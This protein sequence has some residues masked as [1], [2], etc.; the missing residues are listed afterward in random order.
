MLI[1]KKKVEGPIFQ[2]N[3]ELKEIPVRKTCLVQGKSHAQFSL[4]LSKFYSHKQDNEAV[5]CM[6]QTT[7]QA[8]V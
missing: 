1:K 5:Q 2:P 4:F 3:L 7:E 6:E 8:S